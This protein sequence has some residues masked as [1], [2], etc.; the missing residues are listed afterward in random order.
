M[1]IRIIG[2]SILTVVASAAAVLVAAPAQAVV[3]LTYATSVTVSDS[4]SSKSLA[5]ACP[6]GKVAI[7]GGAYITGAIGSAS[8]RQL[9]PGQVLGFNFLSVI[10][11]EDPDGYAGSWSLSATA[12]CIPP[13]AGLSYVTATVSDP[14]LVW[15]TASCGAQRIIGHGYTVSDTALAMAAGAE[16][17]VRNRAYLSVEPSQVPGAVTPL[18]GTAVAVCANAALPG[19]TQVTVATATNSVNGKSATAACPA[20]TQVIG[21]NGDLFDWRRHTVIDDLTLNSAANSVTVTG[22]EDQL[23]NP[24][25]WTAEASALCAT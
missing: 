23:G 5:V 10:A 2:L 20:G 22:Y 17:D 16:I 11:Q 1:R 8:I 3:G 19:L 13:P 7:G 6:S 25:N 18:T 9:R 21:V 4:A 14:S 24:L 12:V 15:A